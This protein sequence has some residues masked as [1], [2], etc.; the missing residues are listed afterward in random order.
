M[1]ITAFS[2]STSQTLFSITHSTAEE[3]SQHSS[4]LREPSH[5][6]VQQRATANVSLP[7]PALFLPLYY[8]IVYLWP[9]TCRDNL[10]PFNISDARWSC[11]DKV[12]RSTSTSLSQLRLQSPLNQSAVTTMGIQKEGM[13]YSVRRQ[14]LLKCSCNCS[15]CK[16][17]GIPSQPR[18]TVLNLAQIW[19]YVT[20]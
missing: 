18:L 8:A 5:M 1:Y 9:C 2:S 20:I 19:K 3:L 16:E 12:P 15:S 11:C 4:E 17:S 6:T 14:R 10:K 13:A 7:L